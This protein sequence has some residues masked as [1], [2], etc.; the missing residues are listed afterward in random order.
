[1]TVDLALPEPIDPDDPVIRFVQVECR[2]GERSPVARDAMQD[3]QSNAA[4]DWHAIHFDTTGHR[5]FYRWTLERGAGRAF[6]F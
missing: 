3:R 2:C 6:R 5:A 4:D 1:M